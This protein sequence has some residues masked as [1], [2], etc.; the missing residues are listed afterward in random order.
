MCYGKEISLIGHS[1]CLPRDIEERI[2][3]A[4]KEQ[5]NLGCN[6]F[7]MGTHGDFDRIAMSVCKNLQKEYET[8]F[9]EVVITSL[10]Q[11]KPIVT[12]DEFGI[13]KDYPYGGINTIMYDIEECHFKRR[14]TES[15]RQMID[16][17]DTLICYVN[18]K[19][20]SNGAKSALKY[21]VKQGIKVINIHKDGEY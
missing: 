3:N 15:N 7:V 19:R 12:V 18:E 16:S 13:C 4:V 20:L 2:S 9:F 6:S 8:L 5:I 17:S 11:I 14:I 10:N 1:D 21:A